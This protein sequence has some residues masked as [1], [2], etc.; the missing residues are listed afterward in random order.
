VTI[1]G[2]LPFRVYIRIRHLGQLK[3]VLIAPLGKVN[4]PL[5]KSP[6][7]DNIDSNIGI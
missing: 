7:S 5:I 3:T 2:R 1:P 4:S 6:L